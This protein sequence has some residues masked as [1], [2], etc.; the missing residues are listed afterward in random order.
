MLARGFGGQLIRDVGR[1]L[2]YG[3]V[4]VDH[5]AMIFRDHQLEMALLCIVAE[6]VVGNF[7]D[8]VSASRSSSVPR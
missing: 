6:P 3:G 5:V 1:Q 7:V 8:V 2:L 4:R